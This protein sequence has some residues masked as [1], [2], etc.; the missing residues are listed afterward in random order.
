MRHPIPRNVAPVV[1]ASLLLAFS[2]ATH[3]QQGAGSQADAPDTAAENSIDAEIQKI[4]SA[5]AELNRLRSALPE[6]EEGFRVLQQRRLDDQEAAVTL[7]INVLAEKLLDRQEAEPMSDA[8]RSQIVGWL[9]LMT[10]WLNDRMSRNYRILGGGIGT[11]SGLSINDAAITAIDVG[12]RVHDAVSGLSSYNRMLNNLESFDVDVTAL[13]QGLIGRAREG[14]EM[15]AVAIDIDS[16]ELRKLRYRLSLTPDDTE[17]LT[18]IKIVELR[19]HDYAQSLRSLSGLLQDLDIDSS[20]YRSLVLL[21]TGDVASQI[22]DTG[23]IAS[24]TRQWS[25]ISWDWINDNGLGL[26]IKLLVFLGI[27][28]AF[29]TL[30]RLTR[31]WVDRGVQ[32]VNL[33]FLLRGM[34]VSTAANAIMALG[35]MFALSQIGVSLGPL[36]AGLG[37]LGFIIGFALQDTLGNFASGMMILVYRPYD[38]GDVITAGGVTGKVRDMSLVY[39]VINTFD[40][41][42]MIVPNSKIWGDVIQNVTSQRVRRVDLVFGISYSDDIEKAEKI[43][44][45]II[46]DHELTLDDPEPTVKLHTLNE[47]SVDFIV[48]PWVKSADY[49]T[50]YWDITREVKM[51][52]D[53]EGISIPFPQRDVHHYYDQAPPA[54]S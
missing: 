19:R 1:V 13:R 33:S 40:N 47:S 41:Q 7:S 17:L 43:L 53:R 10:D 29:R 8:Q 9:R 5:V 28:F 45:Q 2:Q 14:A 22:F 48:R 11:L 15:T 35:L 49:W 50:V 36:L 12:R 24:L 38:V 26:T 52:F 32:R 20:Q 18:M 27:I 31:R 21:V 25:K 46:E 37:V 39:T 34:I 3:A 6:M 30:S 4:T 42:K 54:T 23:A 44:G 51:R 16:D